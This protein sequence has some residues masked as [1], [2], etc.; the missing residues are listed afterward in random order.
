M[1]M[2]YIIKKILNEDFDW[3]SD[4]PSFIE[5]LEP[6]TVNNPKNTYRLHWSNHNLQSD[7]MDFDSDRFDDFVRFV[8]IM[9]LSREDINISQITDLYLSGGHD[10]LLTDWHKNEIKNMDDTEEIRD[11]VE[12]WISEEL[13][14]YNLI[15]EDGV[16]LD[17]NNYSVTYFDGFGVE[18]LTKINR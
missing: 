18:Y 9:E 13:Y 4:V 14:D 11:E 6:I 12:G 5:I 16:Y 8:K 15:D 3:L 7:F 1:I 2:K 10:Y 17:I